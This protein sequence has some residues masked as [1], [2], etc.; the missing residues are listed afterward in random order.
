VLFQPTLARPSPSIRLNVNEK[1]RTISVSWPNFLDWRARAH[2]FESLADSREESL[3]LTGTDRAQRVP[4]RRV[5]GNF[6]TS[7]ASRRQSAARSPPTTTGRGAPPVVIVSDGFWRT[8][9]G[10]DP[11]VVGRTLRLDDVVHT[12]VGVLP[13]GF[14]Y[15]RSYGLF[16]AMGSIAADPQLLDRGNHTGFHAVGRLNRT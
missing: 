9:L 6:F 14:Q 3:T 12:V 13:P 1:D 7:S 10:A 15:L 16:V 4:G 8:Q 11:A 5:T 2:S